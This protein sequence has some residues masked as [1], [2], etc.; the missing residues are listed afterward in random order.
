MQV[1]IKP[2]KPN[3][4]VYAVASKS[5]AHRAIICSSLADVKTNIQISHTSKD[6]EATLNCIKQMGADIVKKD[7]AYEITPI[8]KLSKAPV[9]DCNESG[10]TLRLLL[11]VLAALGSGATFVGKGRLPNRP[12]A[13]IVDLLKQHGNVFSS[14]CL[15]IT[16]SGKTTSGTFKIAGNV[17]SQF[18]SGLLFALPLLKEKSVIEITSNLESLA[19]VKMTIYTLKRFGVNVIQEENR[20]ILNGTDSYMSPE[21]YAVEGDWSNSAFFI[22]MGAIG[23]SVTIKNLNFDSYQSDKMILDVLSLAGVNYTVSENELTVTKSEIKPFDLDVSQCPDLFPVLAVLASSAKG[24]STLYNAERLRIKESDRI[25]S[26]KELL[27]NLG[28]HAEETEDSLIIYG[29]G[30]LKGGIADSFNDHR[31]AMSAFCA[32]AICENDIILN[33]A[34][35]IDKS[36]PTFIEDL[37]KIAEL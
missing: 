11:P 23:G 5:D 20:F 4:T 7:N 6:I 8:K 25:R 33:N 36:Y 12:M 3:G 35:A 32:S 17:S 24:R 29:N 31:I 21:E 27:L 10:S 14:S 30:R 18:I 22:V 26:T 19:Y 34:E 28:G 13:L 9:L 2:T 15:P 1:R 16:V 37:S